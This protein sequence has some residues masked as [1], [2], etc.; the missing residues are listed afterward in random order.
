VRDRSPVVSS[1]SRVNIIVIL[2][3]IRL[4]IKV[5]QFYFTGGQR[6]FD[7]YNPLVG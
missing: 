7:I 1:Q 3:T 2:L 4:S 5:Y 6:G